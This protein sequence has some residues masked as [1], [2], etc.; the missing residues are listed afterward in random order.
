MGLQFTEVVNAADKFAKDYSG[1][2][3]GIRTANDELAKS[4]ND[5]ITAYSTLTG[6]DI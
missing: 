6:D 5:L 2:L 3:S 4:I 1:K